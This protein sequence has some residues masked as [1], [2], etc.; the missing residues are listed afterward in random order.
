MS[1]KAGSVNKRITLNKLVILAMLIAIEIIM[2]R[3]LSIAQ[4][5]M[6]FSFAFIPVVMAGILYG[7]VAGG[8]VGG[9]S[10]FIGALLFP[11]G[12]YFPGYT[13]TAILIG[14]VYSLFLYK[15]QTMIRIISSVVIVNGILSLFLNSA[16][17]AFTSGSNYFAI[18][19]SRGLQCII[20]TAA[21]IA[22]ISL[23]SYELMPRLKSAI[24]KIL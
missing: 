20:M 19:F 21:S 3:F 16:W 15:K 1:K 8:V 7:P 13:F 22:V 2:S 18:V 12:P 17:I 11:I 4:W 9:V 5:N 23:M 24:L 6:K 14:V 10:D